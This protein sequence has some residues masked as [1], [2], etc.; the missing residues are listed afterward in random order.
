V[1]QEIGNADRIAIPSIVLGEYRF[2]V[3]ASRL[4]PPLESKLGRLERLA[5]VLVVDAET[6]VA[7]ATVRRELKDAGTPIP[8][9]DVWIAALVRQC[10]LPLLSNDTHFDRV[11][12]I[13]RVGW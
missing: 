11:T 13:A 12:G 8:D 10:S 2:G 7:Y 1:C 6:A 5:E 9:N 4:R 3:S